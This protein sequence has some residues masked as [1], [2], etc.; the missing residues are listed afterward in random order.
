[1][2]P[3]QGSTRLSDYPAAKIVVSCERCG[4]DVRYDKAAMLAA[5]GDR[6]LTCLL[7]DIARRNGC[8]L[9][10]TQGPNPY[11]RCKAIYPELA[12]LLKAA[13]RL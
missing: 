7:D 3:V 8:T 2:K 10:D 13:G 4:L 1:M 6:A 12:G 11:E 5:G 9:I